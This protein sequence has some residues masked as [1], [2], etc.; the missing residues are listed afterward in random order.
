MLDLLAETTPAPRVPP[1]ISA[2]LTA[3]L[4]QLPAAIGGC[5]NSPR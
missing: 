2:L 4:D 1:T 3:R 5:S